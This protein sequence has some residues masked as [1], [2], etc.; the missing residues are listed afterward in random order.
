MENFLHQLF[1]NKCYLC[2]QKADAICLNCLKEINF[3]PNS[4]ESNF[5]FYQYSDVAKKIL[6][7]SK[8]PPYYFYLLKFLVR[9][10]L[11][12]GPLPG[13]LSK[14]SDTILCPVPLSFEKL[15]ERGFNQAELICEEIEKTLEIP[16]LNILKRVRDT[17]PLYEL[18]KDQ[19]RLELRNSFRFRKLFLI[20]K[21][22][23]VNR[24]ILID[25]LMTT[26]TTLNY[27]KKEFLKQ[28]F[29]EVYFL[30]LFRKK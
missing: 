22:L 14:N 11:K 29:K 30:T 21:L 8:Y 24:I 3:F 27:C 12:S 16:Y 5:S 6:Y 17:R 18:N 1:L 15:Y 4:S 10:Y 23:R 25:D 28:G 20:L 9:N 26:S 13:F 2:E 19:R 7:L